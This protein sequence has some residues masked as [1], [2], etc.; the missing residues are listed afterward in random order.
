MKKSLFVAVFGIL[1]FCSCSLQEIQPKPNILWINSDDLGIE[2][3]C[4]GN[5]DVSTP[6]IDKLAS[7]GILF[8]RAYVTAPICSSSR[9]SMITGMYP[10]SINCLEHRTVDMRRLPEGVLPITEY[11]RN[12]GYFCT[13]GHAKDMSKPGKA[14]FNFIAEDVFDG[15]DW[16]Q[17]TPGQ[18][19][20]AQAQIF[21]PHRPFVD[22]LLN[23][24]SYEDV[25]LPDC[26]PD[27]PLLKADW[28]KYLE[29]VQIADKIVG[30][31]LERL[32]NEGLADNTIVFF[33]GDNGR[34]HLRDK[35]F[36]YEGGLHVPLIVRIP[37][38]VKSAGVDD[39]LISMIDIAATSLSLAGIQVP[40]H[41]QGN[42]FLGEDA[43][44]RDYV[45]GFRQRSGDAVDDIRSI[46][47]GEYKLIWNRLPDIPWMQ[48]SGYKK[49]E[50]PAYTLY[51]HL[52]KSGKLEEPFAQFMA[53]RRSEIELYDLNSDPSELNN[54]ADDESFSEIKNELFSIL[55][56]SLQV[57]EEEMIPESPETIEKAVTGSKS[58]FKSKV[59]SMELSESATDEEF[60]AYW[61]N[62]LLNNP[63]LGYSLEWHDEFDG[64]NLDTT[65]WAYR[66]DN[67][68]RSIQLRENV[69]IADGKLILNLRQHSEP[70][71]GKLAS[72]AGIVSQRK[73]QYGY[74][75]VKAKLGTRE[76][77]DGD[78]IADEGWHH[79]FWAMAAEVKSSEVSTTYPDIRRTEIDCYENASDHSH[80]KETGLNRFTQ[81]VIVWKE[82][83]S[84]WGRL[85]KPPEDIT[86]IV[87]FNATEWHTYG[88]EWNE[89]QIIFN[90]DGKVTQ[91]AE[92]PAAEF[93]HDLINVW[94]T[95]ISANWCQPGAQD[96]RAEY[97]YFRFFKKN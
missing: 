88:F 94:L 52:Y 33:F 93:E 58:Y 69:Q 47:N 14:D 64:N 96:S 1:L 55:V 97:D 91:V 53:N 21:E 16:S 22:D 92:Y 24:V 65:K 56:D 42:R 13:N 87:G 67:K 18:P 76:D 95:A 34:P 79:S 72:G 38:K 86:E 9:S 68:H 28:A 17:R 40:V 12:A 71:G 11:F 75:E 15:T 2:L 20:F 59:K 85:P 39:Q 35:Q 27:H 49:S 70:I 23:P 41:M 54:I 84:E 36:L 37:E 83:G 57:F 73:F 77:S 19:F 7:E 29:S 50:Y 25:H 3:G 90:V 31:I 89:K 48:M 6:N 61:E 46:S 63:L 81:H 45:F 26:Y 10:T 4:Y 5:E 51:Y 78:G 62:K 80:Q 74:Y 44:E 30:E 43:K 32:E 8:T 82:D 60:I 66:V